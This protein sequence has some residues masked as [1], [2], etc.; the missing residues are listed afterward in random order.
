M[1]SGGHVAETIRRS[2]SNAVA[3]RGDTVRTAGWSGV[4]DDIV[5]G[6]D[7]QIEALLGR[8]VCGVSEADSATT[9]RPCPVMQHPFDS[10]DAINDIDS[11][12]LVGWFIGGHLFEFRVK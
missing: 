3:C 7:E 5:C 12:R 2:S 11:G 8:F 4:S 6:D 9:A 1:F 10:D